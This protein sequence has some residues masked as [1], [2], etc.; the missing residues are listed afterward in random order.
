MFAAA[1]LRCT[2]Q[3]KAVY[4]ALAGSCDHPT[5]DELHRS[6]VREHAGMS[7]ATVYNTLEA[8]C[9]AGMARKL[10]GAGANGSARYDA[11]RTE[12][13]HLRCRTTGDV[14]DA[15]ADL[16]E[17]VVATV[18]REVLDQIEQRTGFKIHQLNIELIGEYRAARTPP[19]ARRR[20]GA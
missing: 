19:G 13:L 3:R 8:I 2:R 17:Q 7:L 5:A 14:A 10:A 15:P 6:V 4:E 12:H 16:S 11:G 20:P 1:G 9:R 18:P